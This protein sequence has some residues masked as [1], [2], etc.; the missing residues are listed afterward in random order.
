M[1]HLIFV[2][3]RFFFVAFG[4]CA[5]GGK[6]KLYCYGSVALR[7]SYSLLRIV[8]SAE[9]V[10]IF[11]SGKTSNGMF[12]FVSATVLAAV[13]SCM[14]K[15]DSKQQIT[16]KNERIWCNSECGSGIC[17]VTFDAEIRPSTITILT[18]E[19]MWLKRWMTER[20]LWCRCN[21]MLK[22][23]T[24][25]LWGRVVRWAIV[26]LQLRWIGQRVQQ[27]T[28]AITIQCKWIV[29]ANEKRN[30]CFFVRCYCSDISYIYLAAAIDIESL[31]DTAARAH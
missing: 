12:A 3:E 30:F 26:L 25:I 17:F 5:L 1:A 23:Y 4:C 19:Q 14:T 20:A 9:T 10:I 15:T 8:Y 16:M 6:S 18:F 29:A 21:C 27:K 2:V 11:V 7:R 28:E 24:F 22:I 31:S 13:I